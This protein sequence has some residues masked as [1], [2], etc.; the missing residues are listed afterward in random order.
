MSAII[1]SRVAFLDKSLL[2]KALQ[3]LQVNFQEQDTQIVTERLDYYGNQKFRLDQGRYVFL[4]DSSSNNPHYQWRKQ[5]WGKWPTT[6]AFL[7]EL[8]QTYN[9]LYQEREAEVERRR[10]EAEERRARLEREKLEAEERRRME[11]E[12]RRIEE[13]RRQKEEELRQLEEQR[14]Q[15]V[16]SRKQEI[17]KQA[18]KQGYQVKEKQEGKKVKLVLVRHTY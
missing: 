5:N 4:F 17:I 12:L 18:Q 9:R 2:L 7:D 3:E 10:K 16:E 13:E 15:Y 1:K 11:A 6:N 14:K 8:E